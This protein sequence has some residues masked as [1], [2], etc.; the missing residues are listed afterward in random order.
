MLFWN[1]DNL[2]CDSGIVTVIT[3]FIADFRL[4]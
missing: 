1:S 3:V 4:K 2:H